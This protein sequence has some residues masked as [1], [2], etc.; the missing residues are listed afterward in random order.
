MSIACPPG[1]YGWNCNVEC[2]CKQGTSARC[3]EKTGTCDDGCDVDR[4]GPHCLF[5]K[6]LE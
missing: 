5:G 1:K 4:Y 6:C 2:K 3:E